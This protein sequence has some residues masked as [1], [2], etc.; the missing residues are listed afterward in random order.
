LDILLARLKRDGHRVLI[1]CQMT[2]MIDI[3]EDFMNKKK[4]IFF[5]LDGSCNIADRRDMVK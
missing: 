2:K 1:F 4:Y 5:R 3:L